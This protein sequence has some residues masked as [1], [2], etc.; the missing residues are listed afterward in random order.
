MAGVHRKTDVPPLSLRTAWK[1]YRLLSGAA[2]TI[3]RNPDADISF[4]DARVSWDHA[5]ISVAGGTWVL[6]DRGSRHGTWLGHERVTRLTITGPCVVR[7]ANPEDGPAMTL[8]LESASR[9]APPAPS[10][11]V[12]PEPASR[13][14]GA[15]AEAAAPAMPKARAR[16]A[17]PLAVPSP[18][19]AQAIQGDGH[20]PQRYE[21]EPLGQERGH[22]L[23]GQCPD[24]VRVGE[25]FS[26]LAGVV[27]DAQDN[28]PPQRFAIGDQGRRVLLVLHAPGLQVLSGQRRTIRVMPGEDPAPVM[29]E[30]RGDSPGV[31]QI[32][33]TAWLGGAYLG[34]LAL[35]VSVSRYRIRRSA[36]R[37]TFAAIDASPVQG[38]VSLV[39]R[40]DP[41]R[42]SH[43]F[44]FRDEDSPEEVTSDLAYEPGPRVEQTLAV[45]ELMARGRGGY[46]PAETRDYLVSVGAGLWRELIP[47]QLREQFWDRRDR[48]SQLT[49]L[50]DRDAVPWEL[51]YPLDRGHDAGFLVEQFPVTRLVFGRRPSRS[52]GLFP[53]WFVLPDGSPSQAHDEISALLRMFRPQ[54]QAAEPVV[55]ALTPLLDLIS[56]G[57]FGLLHFACHNAFDAA[58]GPS[59]SL[60]GGQFTP[61]ELTTAAIGQSLARSAP[62]VFIN[63]CRGA[64]A[65]PSYHQLDDWARAFLE[66]GAAA[67]IG[68]L[69]TVRD[70]AAR[71]FAGELYGHLLAGVTLGE[72]VMRARR[73]AAGAPGDPTWLAYAVYGDPRATIRYQ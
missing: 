29:F 22:Y 54:P 56:A 69:W 66:A 48:I 5:A 3:G 19:P 40:Y 43:R 17:P 23:R 64:G 50:A 10:G 73:A 51:L 47:A 58:F 57:E 27:R 70:S 36:H 71:D 32:T 35:E 31:R 2:Y 63:A 59:I 6:E 26:V 34:E 53:P 4:A 25:T 14:N 41:A 68:S 42:N 30:L 18:P 49:I 11:E 55:S 12:L 24:G 67:V 39:V 62:T 38:A 21:P 60:D 44:E 9:P 61:T 28:A 46:S 52:L 16:L 65:S 7:F 72:A 37:D 1:T 15:G 33:I 13:G 45:L 8:K 20:G